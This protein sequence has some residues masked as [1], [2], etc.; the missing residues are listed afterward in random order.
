MTIVFKFQKTE[1]GNGNETEET[2]K[3]VVVTEPP[4]R[5]SLSAQDELFTNEDIEMEDLETF[6]QGIFFNKIIYTVS[7][8][9]KKARF[10]KDCCYNGFF[11]T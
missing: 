11:S 10:K 2:E 9:F 5:K 3:K 8:R 1:D 4:T 6:G 7:S